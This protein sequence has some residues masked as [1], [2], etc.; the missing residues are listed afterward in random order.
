MVKSR[1]IGRNELSPEDTF[2][3]EKI[4]IVSLREVPVQGIP[5]LCHEHLSIPVLVLS[6]PLRLTPRVLQ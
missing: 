1:S 6:I 4:P 2:K 5:P 3:Q